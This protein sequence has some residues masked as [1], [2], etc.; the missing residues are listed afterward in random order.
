MQHLLA[1]LFVEVD[2]HFRVRVAQETVAFRLKAASKL[3]KI[4]NFTVERDHQ[5]AIGIGHRLPRPFAEVNNRQPA[6]TE[7]DSAILAPPF[8]GAIGP[9]RDHLI[10][11]LQK[12]VFQWRIGGIVISE[13]AV[14]P[15]HR[16]GGIL[17]FTSA[18]GC[19]K[20]HGVGYSRQARND[21]AYSGKRL[22]HNNRCLFQHVQQMCEGE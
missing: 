17:R 9:A 21:P 8:T 18:L 3:A 22:R 13:N 10:A 5:R 4:V 15:A 12:L 2:E 16:L 19:I 6:M 14:Q 7:P 11:G 1:L 20:E